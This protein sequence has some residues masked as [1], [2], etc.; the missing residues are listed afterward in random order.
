MKSFFI[1]KK[2]LV[3]IRNNILY[4]FGLCAIITYSTLYIFYEKNA[5]YTFHLNLNIKDKFNKEISYIHLKKALY[6][7]V[8]FDTPS[9]RLDTLFVEFAESV[10]ND[11][12]YNVGCLTYLKHQSKSSEHAV[13]IFCKTTNKPE[14]YLNDQ[15]LKIFNK[16]EEYYV[17]K[18]NQTV[19]IYLLTFV[20]RDFEDENLGAFHLKNLSD[21]DLDVFRINNTKGLLLT[22]IIFSI[23]FSLFIYLSI[24]LFLNLYYKK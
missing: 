10:K 7:N 5:K 23:V 21:Y 2:T 18:Y 14:N 9:L 15:I 12:E 3:K 24:N 1:T 22:A 6:N 4:I 16:N 17:N 19:D 13:R 20:S 11:I 8:I